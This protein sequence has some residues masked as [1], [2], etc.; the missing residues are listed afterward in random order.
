MLKVKYFRRYLRKTLLCYGNNFVYKASCLSFLIRPPPFFFIFFHFFHFFSFFFIFF[1]FFPLIRS[2]KL[3]YAFYTYINTIIFV[4][5][6]RLYCLSCH[7][8]NKAF[9]SPFIELAPNLKNGLFK[10]HACF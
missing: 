10:L 9:K 3:Y 4:Y 1:H 2:S 5:L 7:L 6:F 8:L